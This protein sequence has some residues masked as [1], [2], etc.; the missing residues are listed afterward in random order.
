MF[1]DG[2]TLTKD[3]E[4]TSSMST[5]KKPQQKTDI[6]RWRTRRRRIRAARVFQLTFHKVQ[7]QL[8]T[9]FYF[10]TISFGPQK[11]RMKV[12]PSNFLCTTLVFFFFFNS[13]GPLCKRVQHHFYF[14]FVI[15]FF[16]KKIQ[17]WALIHL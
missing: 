12:Q 11:S 14:I 17:T 2:E 15:L 9:L 7:P 1:M 4:E 6:A 13:F 3:K 8:C 5:P 10:F 16:L